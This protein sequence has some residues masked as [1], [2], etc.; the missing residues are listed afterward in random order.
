MF[1]YRQVL[2]LSWVVFAVTSLSGFIGCGPTVKGS[3]GI[4]DPK[5]TA[6]NP[7]ASSAGSGGA[8]QG[9]AG[10]SGRDE[11]TLGSSSLEQMQR[12]ERPETSPLSPLKDVFFNFDSYDLDSG[13]RETLKA[14]AEWLR[15]HPSA[16]VQIEGHCD[17]RGTNEYNLALGTRRA[18]SAKDYVV[19][20]G[21]SAARVSTISYG[22]EFPLDPGHDE[23]AWARNRRAHFAILNP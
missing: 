15:A 3:A 1:Q 6:E 2:F 18:A 21:I 16:I 13:A 8:G 9:Q 12:G 11:A 19:Q 10:S 7:L 5:W 23:A 20:L 4:T 22:E 17:E 14:N